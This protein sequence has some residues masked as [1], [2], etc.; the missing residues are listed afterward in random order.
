[1]ARNDATQPGQS[2]GDARL[3]V[4]ETSG[5][6]TFDTD[7]NGYLDDDVND[8]QNTL[9]VGGL[10]TWLRLQ[11]SGTSS[12]AS[13]SSDG[14]TWN[15]RA[16]FQLENASNSQDVGIVVTAPVEE[17]TRVEIGEFDVTNS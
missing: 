4:N 2:Q 6:I 9:G 3:T 11:R 16:S 17:N 14:S 1:M 10:P 8:D 15:E 13:S 7:A 12:T 5:E